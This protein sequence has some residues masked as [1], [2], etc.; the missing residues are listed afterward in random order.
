MADR[1]IRRPP[2]R[3]AGSAPAGPRRSLNRGSHRSPAGRPARATPGAS[4]GRNGRRGGGRT[5]GGG[6]G[7]TSGDVATRHRS[8]WPSPPLFVPGLVRRCPLGEVSPSE[9]R[10][11]SRGGFFPP[12]RPARRGLSS[13]APS[14]PRP[15]RG[16]SIFFEGPWVWLSVRRLAAG[17]L[18][19][20]PGAC[21]RGSE[22]GRPGIRGEGR[23]VRTAG[24]TG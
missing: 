15:P 3:P 16:P 18:D 20:E 23:P 21:I 13:K 6:P 19:A 14:R 8:S 12:G 1:P 4:G 17:V 10:T 9:R 5:S 2:R 22:C 24:V 11:D 7:R